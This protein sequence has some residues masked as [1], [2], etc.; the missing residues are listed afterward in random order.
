ME[1]AIVYPFQGAVAEDIA[2]INVREGGCHQKGDFC[3]GKWFSIA[4]RGDGNIGRDGAKPD[5]LPFCVA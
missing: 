4:R 3:K 1:S 5:K 2:V